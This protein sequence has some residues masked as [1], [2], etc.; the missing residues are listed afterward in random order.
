MHRYRGATGLAFLVLTAILS[1]GCGNDT[2][3]SPTTTTD[4]TTTTAT[5]TVTE[6]FS[7]TV[8][9]GGAKFYSFTV[10]Q[11]GTVN[12]TLTSVSGSFVPSTV[13]LGLGVGT[14]DATDCTTTSTVNTASGSTAQLTATLAPGVYCARVYDV[15]NLF[16]PADVN[17]QVDHP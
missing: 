13:M 8:P 17:V 9:V 1:F 7:A 11:N 5:P 12:L 15:G 16:A 4:T 10:E 14:P 6:T 2:P 3:T